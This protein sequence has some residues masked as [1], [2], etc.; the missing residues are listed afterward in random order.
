MGE[1]RPAAAEFDAHAS[2]YDAALNAG[3]RWT[4]AGKAHYARH[5]ILLLRDRLR[6]L[7]RGDVRRVLDYGCGDGDA[8]PLL[9]AIL[10]AQEVIGVDASREMVAVARTRHPEAR[11]ETLDALSSLDPVDLAYCNGVFH[12]IPGPARP[13][14]L[15]SIRAVLRPG[16]HFALWENH[17]WNPGTRFVMWRIPFDRDAD[18]LSP[19]QGRR[20]L[21][22]AGFETLRTDHLFLLPGGVDVF[23]RVERLVA[24]LPLGGQYQVLA[25]APLV[26][27]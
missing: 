5:R 13:A 18:P 25:R 27:A 2:G 23:R 6:A 9:R 16:G 24:R 4:G 3:L 11:F 1:R 7:G 20:L 22:E 8:A 19:P 21:R 26:S 14:A 17:P 12:H 10:G 15:A